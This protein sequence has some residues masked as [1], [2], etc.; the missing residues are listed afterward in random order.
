MG[1][2]PTLPG[3]DRHGRKLMPQTQ[4]VG[5]LGMS[6]RRGP[7]HL[8]RGGLGEAG[9]RRSFTLIPFGVSCSLSFGVSAGG[10]WKGNPSM[11]CDGG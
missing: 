1:E 2:A 6:G 3:I 10:S 5:K 7:A 4:T 11:C 9:A 8:P